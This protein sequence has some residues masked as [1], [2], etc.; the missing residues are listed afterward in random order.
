MTDYAWFDKGDG[1]QV[2]RR[3]PTGP[4]P[5]RSGLAFPMVISDDMPPA[6]HVDGR[7]Y[8]SKSQFRAVTRRE[9]YIEIGTEKLTPKKPPKQDNRKA[10]R[11]ALEKA[12]SRVG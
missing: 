12:R 7:V 1:R 2:Y 5:K 8:T 9:G 11:A 6:E 10:I 3:I 4:E